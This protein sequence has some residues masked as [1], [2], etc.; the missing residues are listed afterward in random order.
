MNIHDPDFGSSTGSDSDGS[1]RY[2]NI[3]SKRSSPRSAAYSTPPPRYEPRLTRYTPYFGKSVI[4][5]CIL[6]MVVE[7]AENGW[8]FE[9]LAV[10]PTLGPSSQVLLR[11]GAKRTDLI[12]AG[13]W[14]RLFAPIVLHGGIIHLAVNMFALFSIGLPLERDYGS[15]KVAYI[16]SVSGFMGILASAIFNP[17]QVSVGASGAIFGLLGAAWAE[18]AHGQGGSGYNIGQ[19]LV[20]TIINLIIGLLPFL[21]NFQHLGG[22]AAGFFCGLAVLVTPEYNDEGK[23]KVASSR[24]VL[25]QIAALIFTPAFIVVALMVLYLGRPA[26]EW[27]TW[28]SVLSC[29]SIPGVLECDPCVQTGVQ[30]GVN[31]TVG[32]DNF[33]LTCPNLDLLNAGPI[34]GTTPSVELAVELCKKLCK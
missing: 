22:M 25:L 7:I 26:E 10:N 4:L 8:K 32:S 21:D 13:D 28:C 5:V 11:L 6:F 14:Y 29:V 27:C 3:N 24:Q 15:L 12:L 18:V 30:L 33:V 31:A 23:R 20:T 2:S 17:T 34:N 1:G 16:F 9:D 19:L